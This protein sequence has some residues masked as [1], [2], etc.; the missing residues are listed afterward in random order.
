MAGRCSTRRRQ[1]ARPG[2]ERRIGTF[3][4]PD[5]PFRVPSLIVCA[6]PSKPDAVADP[7]LA[8]HFVDISPST[9]FVVL[10]GAGHLIHDEQAVSRSVP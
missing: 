3:L 2:T 1:R 4:D 10:D 8:R 6:D 9:E 5:A 7:A